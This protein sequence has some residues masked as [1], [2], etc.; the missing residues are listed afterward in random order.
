LDQLNDMTSDF[1]RK[2]SHAAISAPNRLVISFS[3][4]YNS[5]KLYCERPER[6]SR[7]EAAVA[8]VTGQHVSLDF[9]VVKDETEP[10]RPAPRPEARNSRQRMR[11]M[12]SHPFVQQAMEVFGAELRSVDAPARSDDDGGDS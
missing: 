12:Y 9:V 3:S 10:S 1:A 7:L 5:S 8:A 6:R 4:K 2:F 11:E